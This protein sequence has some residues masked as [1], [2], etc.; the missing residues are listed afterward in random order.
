MNGIVELKTFEE[1]PATY[2]ELEDRLNEFFLKFLYIPLVQEIDLP[3]N[4]IRNAKKN[5]LT[6]A[7]YRGRVTYSAGA[8][9]GKFNAQI[10]K[11][12]KALGAK[13]DRKTSSYKLPEDEI[14]T[15]VKQLIS[16]GDLHFQT[17]MSKLDDKL[18]KVIPEELAENFKCADIFDKTLHK[19]DTSFRKNI[20]NITV[21][22]ELTESQRAKIATD[23]QNNM[24]LYIKDWTEK[25]IKEL[26]S[27]IYEDITAGARRESLIPPILK[28]T[29]T[30][31]SSHEQALNKAKFL[32]HQESRLM[33][34]KFKEVRYKDAGIQEYIWRCVHR[35]FDNT[36]G[37]HSPGNVRYSHGILNGKIFKFSDPPVTTNPGEPSRRNNPGQDYRCRCFARPI[38]RK[39]A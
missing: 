10:S 12:L 31:Q 16:A 35:P 24:K 37:H 18:A 26:R 30:I 28:I 27:K 39:K 38:L 20:R 2:D 32:A 17:Q 14:P 9:R 1:S 6:D 11:E 3:K 22:P 33:M 7:L 21:T 23:W 19:A 36:P 25:Q 13:F 5:P 15:Q 29:K 4:I 34:A 8:F